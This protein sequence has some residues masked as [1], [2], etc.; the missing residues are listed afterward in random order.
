MNLDNLS[1]LIQQRRS[2]FP[3]SYID[4]PIEENLIKTILDN[5]N[6]APNHKRTEPWRFKVLKGNAR[7]RLGN[8]LANWYK[9]NT[10][11]AAFSEKKYQKNLANPQRA[12]CIIAICMQRDP[13]ERVPEWEEIAATACAVQ[14]MWLTCTAHHIGAYWSTPKAIA[15]FAQFH[16]LQEGEK[17]LGLF[18]MGYYDPI[19]IPA[20][21]SPISQKTI[22]LEE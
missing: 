4:Q 6:W 1:Q 8:F 7:Q 15:D 19:N 13:D 16:P 3:A 9:T 21:R 5:A 2:I 17:C 11:A 18:Y 22:W 10:P 12:N 20:S 14:N